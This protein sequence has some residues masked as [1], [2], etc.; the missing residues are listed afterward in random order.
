MDVERF[1]RDLPSLFDDFPA[2]ERPLDRRFADVLEQVPGLATENTLA[3]VNL[4][5]GCLGPGE[6]YLEAG[7]F[8]G[9]SL[10]AAGLEGG[11]RLVAIDRFSMDGGSPE[12]LRE[13][14]DRFHVTG[15]RL[16]QGE[17]LDVLRGDALSGC[18]AGVFYYDADHS[19]EAVLEA[20]RLVRTHLAT[21]A[22]IVVDDADWERVARATDDFVAGEPRA[23]LALELRGSD[24]G[25]PQWWEGVRVLEWRA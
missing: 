23:R 12:L 15:A 5:A 2:A 4:A 21:E 3:L 7:T 16:I 1:L 13:N 9:T 11:R 18:R 14:L 20:L 6:C 24:H 8:R 10:I 17:V 19:Y 25:S 22:L